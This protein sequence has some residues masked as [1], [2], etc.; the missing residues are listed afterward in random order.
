MMQYLFKNRGR[1][2]SVCEAKAKLDSLEDL[3]LERQT[4][5]QL[6]VSGPAKSLKQFEQELEGWLVAAV[7][8]I[9]RPATGAMR[10]PRVRRAG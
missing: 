3:V 5:D 2:P 10:H 9:P 8:S 6:I 7:R 1:G 4:D